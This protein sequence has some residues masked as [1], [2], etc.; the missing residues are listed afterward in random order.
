MGGIKYILISTIFEYLCV[1][2]ILF[3]NFN[4][5]LS[6]DLFDY[7]LQCI[8]HLYEVTNIVVIDRFSDLFLNWKR[9]IKH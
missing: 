5:N 8:L 7:H 6:S 2:L 3:W 1:V 4:G 9:V